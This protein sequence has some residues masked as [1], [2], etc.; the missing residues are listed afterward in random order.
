[1]PVVWH[2]QPVII[3]LQFGPGGEP[4]RVEVYRVL[5][6]QQTATSFAPRIRP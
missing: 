1:M 5:R 3:L 4:G 6:G 2:T